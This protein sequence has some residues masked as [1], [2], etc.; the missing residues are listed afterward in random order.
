MNIYSFIHRHICL[1][2][3]GHHFCAVSYCIMHIP[4]ICNFFSIH[5]RNF[6]STQKRVNCDKTNL[7]QKFLN[8]A[9]TNFIT[10]SMNFT[11]VETFCTSHTCQ[12]WKN[13]DFSKYF[14]W[15]DLKL[16]HRWRNFR[17]LHI[18]QA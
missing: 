16:L 12:M 8:C 2:Y 5:T 13:S 9:K 4:D 3:L 15:R 7:Q 1:L 11:H 17:F 10:K 14:I 6:F 18:Y